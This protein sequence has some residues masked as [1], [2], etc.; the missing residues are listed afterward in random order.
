MVYRPVA[1]LRHAPKQQRGERKVD[2]ILRSAEVVFAEVGYERATT[3]AVAAH[4]GVAIGSLYQFFA[5][6][7]SILEA[8]AQAYL[9]QTQAAMLNM[10]DIDGEI[11]LEDLLTGLLETLVR[12]QDQRPYFLQCLGQQHTYAVL[13]DSVIELRAAVTGHVV[14][15]LRRQGCSGDA[16]FMYRRAQMCVYTVSALLPLALEAPVRQRAAVIAEI[17]TMLERY[18]QPELLPTNQPMRA[19]E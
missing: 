15:L 8:M 10:L 5:S 12:L 17:V 13:Q 9:D 7:D 14:E 19:S 2:Q 18:L 6:K 16:A 1:A 11:R 4:A 3:N